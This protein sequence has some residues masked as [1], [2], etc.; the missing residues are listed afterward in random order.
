MRMRTITALLTY[1]LAF[2]A[3][4]TAQNAPARGEGAGP[5][6]STE[7]LAM[8]KARAQMM[9]ARGARI[10]YTKKFDLSGLPAY[11]PRQKVHGTIR[12]WGSNYITDGFVG[13]YW[14][15]KFREFHPDVRFEWNMK[16]SRA[17]VPS[18]VF[19]VS[20]IGIGRKVT[21]GELQ[22][23][24]R[25]TDHDPLE[26]EIAT[27]SFDVPGWQPGYGVMVHKD[28]PLT[29]ITME[30]LD[31]IFGAERTGGWDGTNWRPQWA[32]GPEK[33]IRTWGELGLVGEWAD[34]PIN[35]YGLNLRY[36]QAV[37]ISDMILKSSDKWNER[38]KIYANYV[39]ADGKLARDMNE[40]LAEDRY[41][42]GILAAPTVNLGGDA[43][44]STLKILPV[45][46]NEEGPFIPYTLE[47]MQDRSY[48]MHD[49]IYAYVDAEPADPKVIEFLRFVVSREGQELV[50]KDAKYLPLTAAVARAE[51][52]KLDAALARRA[53]K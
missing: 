2:A 18:L 39:T 10:A 36:H 24:Q 6:E 51:L 33:N 30:Q 8:Q 44:E 12:L 40:D 49:E 15:D 21:F 48:P 53:D 32:R 13:G 27:G 14:E 9:S 16:S 5:G 38:L 50:M 17:A 22:L 52:A 46:R 26:I 45:G 3:S 11:Q 34:R 37:E 41:G 47:T 25:Y 31:G 23:F 42:I 35:V 20:D 28:N 19:G 43:A 29:H 7:G 1:L 4:A